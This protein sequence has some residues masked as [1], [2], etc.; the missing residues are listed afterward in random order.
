MRRLLE[1]R[2]D[3]DDGRRRHP[4]IRVGWVLVEDGGRCEVGNGDAARRR[5]RSKISPAPS[6]RPGSSTRTT[7]SS[8]RSRGR[9]RRRPTSSRGCASSIR[10]G[11]GSTPRRS[12]PR[13][14]RASRSL[15]SPAARP[16]SITTTSFRAGRAGC[17]EAEVQAAREL[18]VRIVASRGS[19]DLGESDGGLPPD[20]VVEEARCGARGT[21][22]GWH[23]RLHDA[24][25][26]AMVQIAVAP[27][28]PFSV[29]KQLMADSAEL[30]RRHGLRLHTHL[31]E[32][33]EEDA[34]CRELYGCTPVEYLEE[35]GWTA[36][37]VWCAHCV[38]LSRR[39]RRDVRGDGHRCRALPDVQPPAGS[40]RRARPGAGRRR[41]AGRAR[42]RRL[43][44][45]R[46]LRP[47]LRRQAGAAR[48]ARPRRAGGDDVPGGAAPRDA[49]RR[50]GARRATTSARSRPASARISRSGGP[51]GSSSA[52]P[53][54]LWQG[55]CCRRRIAS[56]GCSSAAR[57]SSAT[58]S[59]CRRT[60]TRSPA[61][62]GS[63]RRG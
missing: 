20:S 59:S 19:M 62:T 40:R 37:D 6:S 38:H 47:L 1:K 46:A 15:R 53:R 32:T 39:G 29:T 57:T 10:S 30:A 22:R 41:G 33:V 3:R 31:A 48:R 50:G 8:R 54:I 58:A 26:G 36:R 23:G 42:R 16:S 9:G 55:S 13:R 45:E 28:S 60:R 21:R 63:R 52:A 14:A 17:V 18:G 44:V 61:N 5:T 24:G 51:T 12:T 2:V 11:R 56:T 7:T 25:A 43:G 34:Y 35:L 4:S 49:R 27:C